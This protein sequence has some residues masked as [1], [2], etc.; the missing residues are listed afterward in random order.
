MRYFACRRRRSAFVAASG[1]F[2]YS[3]LGAEARDQM[4]RFMATRASFICPLCSGALVAAD[5]DGLADMFA[6]HLAK[7]H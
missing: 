6:R 7:V 2:Q 3:R 5:A 1:W 4:D